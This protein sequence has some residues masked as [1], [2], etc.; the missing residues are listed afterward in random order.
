MPTSRHQIDFDHHSPR[1]RDECH[2]VIAELHSSGCPLGYAA[3]NGGFWAIYGYEAVSDAV[4]D[5]GLFSSAH[6]AQQPKGIPPTLT[7]HPLVP[8]DY[9][10]PSVQ[11]F[12]RITLARFSPGAA[13][14]QEPW[15]R[16]IA[17]ELIDE[18]IERGTADLAQELLIPLPARWILGMLGWD[19]GSWANWVASIHSVVHDRDHE[20]ERSLA[21]SIG[22]FDQ[23]TGELNRRRTSPRT[24]DVFSD[25][26]HGEVDGRPLTDTEIIQYTFLLLL[27]GMDTTAG[28]TGNV[29]ELLTREPALRAQ[30]TADPSL[31]DE[32]TEELLRHESPSYGLYRTVTRDAVFH[33]QPLRAGDRVILMYPAAGLDPSI[34]DEPEEVRLERSGNRHMAFA[35][36]PHRCL[37]SHAARVMFRVMIS[38]ILLR[39]PDYQIS[40]AFERFEDAGDVYAIRYLPVRFTP[41]GR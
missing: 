23:I 18:F 32:G 7:P 1:F 10:G 40:G 13:M 31:I 29:L 33:G 39:L 38:E 11:A 34:F 14:A 26:V 4:H 21:A 17:T 6:S 16:K 22:I 19:Q 27:G 25:L 9:D 30:L 8:I 5:T 24:D 2:R 35:L 37:G 3:S 41:A 20:P 36:G 28:L 12:R 15:I